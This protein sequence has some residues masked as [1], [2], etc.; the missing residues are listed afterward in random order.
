MSGVALA[1]TESDS[2]RH[3]DCPTV[4]FVSMDLEDHDSPSATP[5]SQQQL[6]PNRYVLSSRFSHSHRHR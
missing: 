3:A 1:V 5:P 2:G 6:W 4:E